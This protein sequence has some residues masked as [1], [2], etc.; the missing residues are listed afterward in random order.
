[1]LALSLL[2]ALNYCAKNKGLV[3]V[4]NFISIRIWLKNLSC[5]YESINKILLDE[6]ELETS[7]KWTRCT[8][9]K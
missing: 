5:S 2:A 9:I 1:M 3:S 7:T 8:S 6:Y 4:E